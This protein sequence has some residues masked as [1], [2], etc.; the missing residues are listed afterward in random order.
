MLLLGARGSGYS[1]QFAD[2]TP[3]LKLN[4]ALCQLRYLLPV[5]SHWLWLKIEAA[6]IEALLRAQDFIAR[7]TRLKPLRVEPG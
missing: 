2:D 1:R 3:S 4:G 7:S 6:T 5:Y